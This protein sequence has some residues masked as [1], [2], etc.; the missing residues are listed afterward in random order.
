[1][2]TAPPSDAR[3]PG[4]TGRPSPASLPPA[5]GGSSPRTD[6]VVR[7]L[8][9]L[10]VI[11][12]LG[13]GLFLTVSTL[14]FTHGL[15]YSASKVG[16]ALTVAGLCGI[17]ASFPAGRAADRYGAKPALVALHLA[18]A[19]AMA[20]F[21][22]ARS[23]P[24]FLLLACTVTAGSRANSTVRSTLYAHSLPATTRTPALGLL[25]AVNN[26]GIGAGAALGT[27]VVALGHTGAYQAAIMINAATFLLALIP[28]RT[29]P[30]Q[31]HLAPAPAAA[32]DEHRGKR[33]AS[34]LRDGPYLAVTALNAIVNMLYV[35]LEVALP[36]WLV[37][38]T[39]APRPLVGTLLV[40]NTTLVVA[41]QVRATRH[42][43]DLPTAARSFRTGGLLT[44]LACATAA[45]AAHHNPTA[46][47]AILLTAVLLLTLGEVTSQAGSWTLGYALAP[48]HAQGAYQGVFQTGVS[49]TQALGP[50]VVTALVLP[51]GAAGWCTLAAIFAVAA[52]AMP[53]VSRRAERRWAAMPP[54]GTRTG[55]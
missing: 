23:Y 31:A 37:N 14:W 45:T 20:G 17:L 21:A 32:D 27:T 36:L 8:A 47:T 39:H 34:A 10:L 44:A 53:A 28:L 12:A 33:P 35:V 26:V 9:V 46:A 4:A 11:N 38:Y 2:T 55:P 16:L 41:L 52:L 43:G 13:N 1:M 19:V 24:A 54:A 22:V 29:V 30:A 18:Q 40:L 51:H 48:D 6:P 3:T 50:F 49:V 25:R 42:T 5:P 7:A 15:G